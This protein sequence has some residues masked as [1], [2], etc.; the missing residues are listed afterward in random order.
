MWRK[1]NRLAL[2][3]VSFFMGVA[4]IYQLVKHRQAFNFI[5][6]DPPVLIHNQ[7]DPIESVSFQGKR[8]FLGEF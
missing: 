3:G 1:S 2:K 6:D 7:T 5:Y 4:G 8:V